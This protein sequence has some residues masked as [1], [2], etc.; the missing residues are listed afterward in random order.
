VITAHGSFNNGL[1]FG[2]GLINIMRETQ[3]LNAPASYKLLMVMYGPGFCGI[4]WR[5]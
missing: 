2:F 5:K 4:A 3:I 1:Q